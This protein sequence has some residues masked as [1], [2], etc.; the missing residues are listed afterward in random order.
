M[1]TSGMKGHMGWRGKELGAR[2]KDT[3]MYPK[4]E[5]GIISEIDW[6]RTKQVSAKETGTELSCSVLLG[7]WWIKRSGT[8]GSKFCCIRCWPLECTYFVAC[9]WGVGLLMPSKL[10]QKDENSAVL[11]KLLHILVSYMGIYILLWHL[12]LIFPWFILYYIS[13]FLYIFN[14]EYQ[15]ES[16]IILQPFSA[17]ELGHY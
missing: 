12:I 14:W 15:T 6:R 16:L 2:C 17:S 11:Q 7:L 3:K 8:E 10:A 1:G 4:E 9:H 13:I 5:K